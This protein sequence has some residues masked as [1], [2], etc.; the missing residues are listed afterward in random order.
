VPV[1][2]RIIAATNRDLEEEIRRGTFRSDLYYRLNVITLHLPPL[3]DRPTTSPA[4]GA[5]PRASPPP[6]AARPLSPEALAALQAYDWPGNVREL[7]N[8]LE[9]APVLSRGGDRARRRSRPRITDRRRSR[10][11]PTPAAQP[12]AG[13]HR[14]RLH[15]LGPPGGG[16]QQDARGGGA[17]DRS[18]HAVPQARALDALR[19]TQCAVVSLAP[20]REGRGSEPDVFLARLL[21]VAMHELGHLAGLGH[22][23]SAGCVMYSSAHIADTDRKGSAF[24]RACAR[25]GGAFA[26][27][28]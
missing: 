19:G 5:L 14:A 13:D 9:R 3:R 22:C 11:S 24:C 23:A 16:R 10:W 6:G 28:T 26:R 7:E 21:A 2:V 18:L 17:R 1:D 8:A 27:R 4:G 12:A 25:N 15:P 20:L